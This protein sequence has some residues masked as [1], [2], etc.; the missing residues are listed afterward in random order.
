MISNQNL[1][2]AS[3]I[4]DYNQLIFFISITY[5]ALHMSIVS[6]CCIMRENWEKKVT[7]NPFHSQGYQ[8]PNSKK[9]PNNTPIPEKN[10]SCMEVTL[11]SPHSKFEM[12]NMADNQVDLTP[13]DIAG[14]SFSEEEIGKLTIAG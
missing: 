9:V 6:L 14:V 11:N 1:N 7:G 10:G 4:S 2:H 8:N 13:E 3:L 12:T 5:H